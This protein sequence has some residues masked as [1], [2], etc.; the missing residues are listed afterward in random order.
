M[1]IVNFVST[2]PLHLMRSGGC[3]SPREIF[4]T[5]NKKYTFDCP[6][7]KRE[8][9]RSPCHMIT[10]N[11][12]CN[13]CYLK[14]QPLVEEWLRQTY[15][16]LKI[17]RE[18]DND[19]WSPLTGRFLKY[20]LV[21]LDKKI[22]IEID[23]P[24]HFQQ[25]RRWKTPEHTMAYDVYKMAMALEDNF[26]FIRCCQESIANDRI[27][28]RSE[29]SKAIEHVQSGQIITLGKNCDALYAKHLNALK[30]AQENAKQDD[31]FWFDYWDEIGERD[32]R[33]CFF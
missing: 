2:I 27:D 22:I 18:Y 9:K 21:I 5:T 14:T 16:K 1:T 4:R 19:C 24:Q 32:D 30:T 13:R 33:C 10:Q 23:G 11:A 25:V 29:L 6:R 7:C 3:G 17:E 8:F 31:R 15:P 20:D 12:R 26:A 28:W